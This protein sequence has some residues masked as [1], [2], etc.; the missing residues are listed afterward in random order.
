[1]IHRL[2]PAR[3]ALLVV[4]VQEAFAQKEAA[5]ER[6]NNPGALSAIA[7]LLAAVRRAGAPVV[8][9][10]HRNMSPVSRFHPGASGFEPMEAAR[11]RSGETVIVKDVN[12]AFIGTGRDEHLRAQGIEALVVVGITTN[13]CVETTTR[14][15]GNLGYETVLVSDATYTFDRTGPDGRVFA[16]EDI[17]A[18]TLA[19]LHGEFCTVLD[20]D[21]VE[22]ALSA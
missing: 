22:R 11:E 8:H 17:Q 18:M 3:T 6:R 13:H 7:A 16:A 12:S 19:N 21:E 5:G 4:D 10:R 9:I 2:D 20:A 15:A 14:M 1:V